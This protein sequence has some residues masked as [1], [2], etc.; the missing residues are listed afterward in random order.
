MI[1]KRGIASHLEMIIAFAIFISFV[2]FL[3]LYIRPYKQ[4]ALADSILDGLHDSFVEYASTNMTKIFVKSSDPCVQLNVNSFVSSPND[5]SFV[6]S[7]SGEKLNSVFS[8]GSLKVEN[9]GTSGA[10]YAYF[11][12]GLDASATSCTPAPT[13]SYTVGSIESKRLVSELKLENIK[14]EYAPN[15]ARLKEIFGIPSTKDFGIESVDG[16]FVVK[17][18]IPEAAIVISKS[19]ASEVLQKNGS[20]VNRE[21]I[22][23][24]W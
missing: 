12:D 17:R 22:Y 1:G 7:V 20:I 4:E 18:N 10:F 6:K 13:P 16:S 8:S 5:R 14:S 24:V 21:F 11:S 23:K 19:F 9:S 2:T 3:M 15:Y